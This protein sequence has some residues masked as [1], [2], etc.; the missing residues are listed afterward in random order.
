ML[1]QT[2]AGVYCT[3]TKRI[4]CNR[5]ERAC[6]KN[7]HGFVGDERVSGF[8]RGIRSGDIPHTFTTEFKHVHCDMCY[9]AVVRL[10]LHIS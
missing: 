8:W 3:E 7:P 2:R 9:D 5:G 6:R 10:R 1:Y 4:V